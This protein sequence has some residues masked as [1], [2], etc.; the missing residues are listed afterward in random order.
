M[1][2]TTLLVRLIIVNV[3]SVRTVFPALPNKRFAKLIG[4]AFIIGSVAI[5]TPG[6]SLLP[7]TAQVSASKSVFDF[8]DITRL[9]EGLRDLDQLLERWSE[10]TLDCNF[11]E[12]QRDLLAPESKKRL[13]KAAAETGLLDYDKSRT[14]VVKCRRDPDLVR[15]RL[16]LLPGPSPLVGADKLL[17]QSGTIA[18]VD[19]DL[20][21]KYLDTVDRFSSAVASAESLAYEARR[22]LGTTETYLRKEALAAG[23]AE[24]FLD[25]SKTSV[26]ECRDALAD[27]LRLL[28]L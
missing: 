26:Q 2:W 28:N 8:N 9:R 4:R 13:L 16:G 25:K 11:G 14:M 15:A 22:D 6:P 23:S 21:D 18:R 27:I 3:H 1:I 19:P 20:L 10:E 17:R 24:S 5:S 7:V 12:I